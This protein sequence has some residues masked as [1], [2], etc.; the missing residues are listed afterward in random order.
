MKTYLYL[1]G[2]I[3]SLFLIRPEMLNATS[4]KFYDKSI[5]VSGR[6]GLRT[7]TTSSNKP[8]SISLSTTP[9]SLK[10][11]EALCFQT[12]RSDND[13]YQRCSNTITLVGRSSIR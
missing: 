12:V 3:V 13:L 7:I 1:C 2:I 11:E 10:T 5:T 6:P 4:N 8:N 9:L